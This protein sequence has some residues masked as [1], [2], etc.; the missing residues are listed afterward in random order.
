MHIWDRETEE[1]KY[2]DPF[3]GNW[4]YTDVNLTLCGVWISDAVAPSNEPDSSMITC[5]ECILL[6]FEQKANLK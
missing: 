5:D 1:D 3:S 6:R 2:V 4:L